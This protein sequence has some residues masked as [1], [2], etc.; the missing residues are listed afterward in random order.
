MKQV[1]ETLE[2]ISNDNRWF[3]ENYLSFKNKY[4][5]EFIAIKE[6]EII[7]HAKNLNMIIKILEDKKEDPAFILIEFITPKGIEIIL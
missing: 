6:R 5:N 7:A 3:Q 2:R 4:A 1:L